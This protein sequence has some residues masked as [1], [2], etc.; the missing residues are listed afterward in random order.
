[1]SCGDGNG[2]RDFQWVLMW[3]IL[4]QWHFCTSN[5]HDETLFLN[6]EHASLPCLVLNPLV[7]S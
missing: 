5:N 6:P 7:S 4:T 3:A 1:M 2:E